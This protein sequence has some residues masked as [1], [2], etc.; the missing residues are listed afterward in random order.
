LDFG[1]GSQVTLELLPTETRL[2]HLYGR[3]GTFHVVLTATTSE[4]ESSS[5]EIPVFVR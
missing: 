4:G 1:D 5:L 3:A 2:T